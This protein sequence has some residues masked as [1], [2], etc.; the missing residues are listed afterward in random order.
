MSPELK[1]DGLHWI[2]TKS[3]RLWKS[4]L[5]LSARQHKSYSI[6][7]SFRRDHIISSFTILSTQLIST[8]K[9][10]LWGLHWSEEELTSRRSSGHH[11]A[12]E[13]LTAGMVSGVTVFTANCIQCQ[14]KHLLT[15][16]VTLS[17]S[18]C[19]CSLKLLLFILRPWIHVSKAFYSL[20]IN[21]KMSKNI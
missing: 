19:L 16:C 17:S 20:S 6:W 15:L 9:V 4:A 11:H 2:Y 10:T 8:L 18:S 13:S 5:V 3:Q 12:I 21:E 14:S 7:H 1:P